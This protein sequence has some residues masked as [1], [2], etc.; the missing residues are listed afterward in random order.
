MVRRALLLAVLCLVA[1]QTQ[2][3]AANYFVGPNG[4]DT[5][6][7]G[8]MGNPW[9]TLPKAGGDGMRWLLPGDTVYALPGNYAYG[10]PQAIRYMGGTADNPITYKAYNG[11]GTVFM[12]FSNTDNFGFDVGGS[13][14]YAPNYLVFDG[15]N[16]SGASAP[17]YLHDCVG[18]EVKNCVI[19]T[20]NWAWKM[21][22]LRTTS[23][24]FIHNNYLETG[25]GNQRAI[26]I[27]W[28][29]KD[30]VV[31]NNVIARSETAFDVDTTSAGDEYWG[32]IGFFNNIVTEATTNIA[33]WGPR[34]S[35]VSHD[36]NMYWNCNS[37]WQWSGGTGK[38]TNE[39]DDVNPA[40]VDYAGGDYHLAPGSPAIDAGIDV[41]LDYFG[42]APDIGMYEVIPEPGAFAAL[43][44]GLLGLGGLKLRRK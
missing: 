19:T 35:L 17:L 15:L 11:P 36:Y 12:N 10:G 4:S 31:A 28:G 43:A 2:A 42:L 13:G 32:S 14:T 27:D 30:I 1:A 39:T 5:F 3:P 18:I 44:V 41:G 21:L 25:Y 16:I 7:D 33:I 37:S 29:G 26:G 6:G 34:G 40:F 8:S 20:S 9:F 38:N 22:V 24:M 23:D